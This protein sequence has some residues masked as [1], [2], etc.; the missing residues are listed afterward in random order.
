MGKYDKE[1]D[2]ALKKTKI[3]LADALDDLTNKDIKSLFPN[4]ADK[5]LIDKIIES[6]EKSTDRNETITACQAIAL[7]LTVEGAKALKEGFK[8]GKALVI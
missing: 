8:I 1:A 3:A 7:K 4:T 2:A 6:L 5:A